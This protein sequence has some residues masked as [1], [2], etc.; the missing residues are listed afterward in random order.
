MKKIALFLGVL[1]MLMLKRKFDC[2][3]IEEQTVLFQEIVT[4]LFIIMKTFTSITSVDILLKK[5]LVKN[6]LNKFRQDFGYKEGIY[7]KE[8]NG[9]EDN[10]HAYREVEKLEDVTYD[11]LYSALEEIYKKVS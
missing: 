1:M 5:Y 4:T 11:N 10:V 2:K 8:W 6:V 7:I 3:S 9:E